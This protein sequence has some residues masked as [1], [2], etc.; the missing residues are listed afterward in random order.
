MWSVMERSMVYS[1]GM[2]LKKAVFHQAWSYLEGLAKGILIDQY[3]RKQTT[4][5]L[6]GRGISEAAEV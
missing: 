5:K 6:R 4:L 2:L 1:Q 3:H